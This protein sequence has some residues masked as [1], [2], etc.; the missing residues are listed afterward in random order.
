M[1]L[2]PSAAVSTVQNEGVRES[3][4]YFLQTRTRDIRSV[5][6]KLKKKIKI[7]HRADKS[8]F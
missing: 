1:N 3:N 8:L 2:L 6:Q 5:T 7:T 4:F